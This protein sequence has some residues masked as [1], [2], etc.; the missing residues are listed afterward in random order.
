MALTIPEHETELCLQLARPAFAAFS[1]I[2]D[3]F[4][5]EKERDDAKQNGLSCVINAV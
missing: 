2:N 4:S 1:L 3:L 5:W